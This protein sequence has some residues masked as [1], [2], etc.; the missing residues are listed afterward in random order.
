MSSSSAVSTTT[1][2]SLPLVT[3]SAGLRT[4][5]PPPVAFTP[6]NGLPV[7]VTPVKRIMRPKKRFSP[8][9]FVTVTEP[10]SGPVARFQYH[11]ERSPAA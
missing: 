11:S 8:D 6:S 10:D 1:R 2:R 9:A 7:V 5:V 4:F 3:M